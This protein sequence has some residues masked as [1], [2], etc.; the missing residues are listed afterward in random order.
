MHRPLGAST[1]NPALAPRAKLPPALPRADHVVVVLGCAANP[2][3]TPRPALQ[4]RLDRALQEL[5]ADPRAVVVVTGGAVWNASSEAAAMKRYLVEH[6]VDPARVVLEDQA[7]LTL[8]NAELSAPLVQ[9]IGAKKLTLVTER[10]HMNRSRKLF[11]SALAEAGLAHVKV[12]ESAAPDTLAGFD[13]LKKA[14]HELQ[15]LARDVV[16]QRQ[17]HQGKPLAIVPAQVTQIGTWSAPPPGFVNWR[18]LLP[19]GG[20]DGKGQDAAA[21]AEQA[22]RERAARFAPGA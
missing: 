8:E 4:R 22:R 17:L 21:L 9:R 14:V 15:A 3:G 18:A 11:D 5:A 6:G 1:A 2:D 12:R 19:G 13:R 20:A 10:Y 16:N 7:R